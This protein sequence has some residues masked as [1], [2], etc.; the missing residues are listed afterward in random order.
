[1]SVKRTDYLM[2]GA[3]IDPDLVSSKYDDLEAEMY[4]EGGRRFDL[5]YDGMSG[6]YAV[7]GEIIAT[8]DPCEGLEF[9]EIPKDASAWRPEVVE[10]VRSEFPESHGFSLYLFSHFR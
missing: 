2:W 5:I 1:M 9:Q 6:E 7:A 8:S 10:A 4:L 3:K